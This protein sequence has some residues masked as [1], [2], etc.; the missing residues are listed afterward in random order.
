V[1]LRKKPEARCSGCLMRHESCLCGAIP[2]LLLETRL[3]L[4]T[5]SR[6][7][8]SPSN[9]GRLAL[10][11]LSNSEGLVRGDRN[12]PYDLK[13]SLLPNRPSLLLYADPE[14]PVLDRSLRDLG[15]YNLIVPDGNWR[16]THKL[17]RR[18]PDLLNVPCV[19]LPPDR[20]S[21][22]RI[23]HDSK[24]EGLATLEAIAR[25]LG[26]L[27]G[28]QVEA[29]LTT[30]FELQVTSILRSRGSNS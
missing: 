16:Q 23:R 25:A 30:L 29:E 21:A 20:P 27:E 7:L 4:I 19:R 28:P 10:L 22:Y 5:R 14:A 1:S 18:D 3:V 9:T 6:E 12:R 17:R 26:V 2:R 24:A 15:P 8:K 13:G 11:A